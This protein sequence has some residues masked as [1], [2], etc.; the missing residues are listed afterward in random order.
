MMFRYDVHTTSKVHTCA[1][2]SSIVSLSSNAASKAKVPEQQQQPMQKK[3]I[4]RVLQRRLNLAHNHV[5]S[6]RPAALST[7]RSE[8]S[9]STATPTSPAAFK[10]LVYPE[11]SSIWNTSSFSLTIDTTSSN[12]ATVS[13][14]F[15]AKEVTLEGFVH[16]LHETHRLRLRLWTLRYGR[17]PSNSGAGNHGASG[18]ENL[19]VTLFDA[20]TDAPEAVGEA[21]EEEEVDESLLPDLSLSEAHAFRQLQRTSTDASSTT[22]LLT[23][24]QRTRYMQRWKQLK[25]QRQL[26]LSER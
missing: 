18:Y 9:P 3:P 6:R 25:Q 4:F 8:P 24:A 13:P 11:D 10:R 22:A 2:S 15:S 21:V 19:S 12:T 1:L 17:R 26:Q 23:R 7:L 20:H 5:I 14:S 16:W